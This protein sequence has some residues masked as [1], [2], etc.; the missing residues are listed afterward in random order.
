MVQYKYKKLKRDGKN[1]I[2][3]KQEIWINGR[4]M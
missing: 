3:K 1:E 4:A 2:K